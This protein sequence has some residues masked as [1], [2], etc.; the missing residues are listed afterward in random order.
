MLIFSERAFVLRRFSDHRAGLASL[1]VGNE[2]LRVETTAA[3]LAFDKGFLDV[4]VKRFDI[5]VVDVLFG[6]LTFLQNRSQR[7]WWSRAWSSI[8]G[9]FEIFFIFPLFL[10]GFEVKGQAFGSEPE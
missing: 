9:R 7:L 4:G 6:H 2:G 1:L 3:V 5:E 8:F 10:A